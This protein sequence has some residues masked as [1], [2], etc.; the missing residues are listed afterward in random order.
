MDDMSSLEEEIQQIPELTFFY[1]LDKEED[2]QT[3]DIN[4]YI[5]EC[6]KCSYNSTIEKCAHKTVRNYFHYKQ[7]MNDNSYSKYCRY[8][9]HWLLKE[10]YRFKTNNSMQSNYWDECIHCISQKLEASHGN[11]GKKCIFD[12]E[13]YPNAIVSMRRYLDKF[14]SIREYLE[15]AYS[16][17]TDRDK[18]LFYN[19]KRDYYL[20]TILQ[21][22][23]S[24]SSSTTFN[25]NYFK[26]HENCSF[27]NFDKTFPEIIC[28][29]D[30]TCT[31][32]EQPEA[33]AK[34]TCPLPERGP[35][36]RVEASPE[37]AAE[38]ATTN[39]SSTGIFL[40]SVITLLVTVFVFF[41]LYRFSPFGTWLYDHLKKRN[42]L[43]K[44]TEDRMDEDLS[45]I[46]LIN[47]ERNQESKRHYIGYESY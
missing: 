4:N 28:P 34:I 45:E 33:E 20:K 7:H 3:S 21:N 36:P 16:L 1:N 39:S 46:N 6:S 10:K 41:A 8:F 29:C 32:N 22:I 31:K 23:A 38:Y 40:S 43:L 27:S 12:K 37:I 18:C 44:S 26:I 19:K 17:N 9:N 42:I 5:S 15:T 2:L 25:K 13:N 11:S 24:I 30:D 35:E 14:C 47:A